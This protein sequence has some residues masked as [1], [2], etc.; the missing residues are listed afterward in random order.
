MQKIIVSPQREA[1]NAKY[2]AWSRREAFRCSLHRMMHAC[3]NA[4]FAWTLPPLSLL[5]TACAAP[6]TPPCKPLAP[7]PP[8]V[9]SEPL[10]AVNYSLTAAQNILRWRAAVI[11]MSQTSIPQ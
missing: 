5:L 10:P 1:K 2:L 8:F 3:A 4:S 6:S 9:L 7:I 11:D